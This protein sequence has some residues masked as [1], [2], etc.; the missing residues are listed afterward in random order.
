MVTPPPKSVASGLATRL[1]VHA[2]ATSAVVMTPRMK[3]PRP[4][5]LLPVPAYPASSR[6]APVAASVMG[7]PSCQRTIPR[8]RQVKVKAPSR[9]QA[10]RSPRRMALPC[11]AISTRIGTA[12]TVRIA[13]CGVS[14]GRLR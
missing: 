6:R 7:C 12:T 3:V 13:Q 8:E 2:S 1:V 10:Y 11:V 4:T 9:P 5:G 14:R